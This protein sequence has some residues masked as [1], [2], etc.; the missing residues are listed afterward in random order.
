MSRK[1]EFVFLDPGKL[2]DA[3]L[4]LVLVATYPGNP[5]HGVVPSYKFEMGLAGKNV[6]MGR[7]GLRIGWTEH[8][9]KYT[10][11]IGYNV[12]PEYRGHRYAARSCVL[13]FPLARAHS[14]N[15]LWVTCNPDNIASRRTCELVGGVL[16]DTVELPGDREM[17]RR[18]ERLKCRYRVDL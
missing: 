16:V 3:E 1:L 11:H 8:I 14:I 13:L 17:F 2:L 10:G 7:I 9:T 5:S 12:F 4:E 15:P 18:G 6:K